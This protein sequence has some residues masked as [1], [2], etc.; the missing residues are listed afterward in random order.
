MKSTAI[1]LAIAGLLFAVGSSA[2]RADGTPTDYK[3]SED[4]L[5]QHGCFDPCLCPLME[6]VVM[7]G[8]FTLDPIKEHPP[9]QTFEVR[10]VRW[11]VPLLDLVVTGSGT[12]S[13][14]SEF[15]VEHRL[16]LD[17][18]INDGPVQH[19]DSGW[20]LGG[21][22]F[23]HIGAT[24]SI[25]GIYCY[26]IVLSVAADPI[27][28]G[29]Y[30]SDGYVNSSDLADLLSHWGP[31]ADCSADLDTSGNVDAADLAEL[32]SAWGPCLP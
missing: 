11:T 6:E 20:V 7:T 25:N 32:L 8:W 5:Y 31:C 23:P 26:D 24:V 19:F 28:I 16:E 27:C 14:F 12:Y 4:A 9:F 17:L 22:D 21:N 1:P 3:L 10:D 13:V 30:D 15:V 2:A 29:D 18:Q